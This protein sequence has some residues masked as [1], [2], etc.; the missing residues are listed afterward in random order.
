VREQGVKKT[1]AFGIVTSDPQ[2]RM[3]FQAACE[4]LG[5]RLG[6]VVYPQIARS[7]AEL[8]EIFARGSVELAWTP[9]LIAAELVERKLA[10]VAVVSKR[11][12]AAQYRSVIFVRRDSGR[13]T[14]GDLAGSHVAWVD[15][16]SASGYIVPRAYLR[17][18]GH[19]PDELFAYQTIAAS[20]GAV[21]RMVLSR[22]ADAGATFALFSSGLRT[23]IEAGWTEIDPKSAD[24]IHV[25]VNAGI[26]PADCISVA[27]KLAPDARKRLEDAL[28]GLTPEQRADFRKSVGAEGY[29]R[30]PLGHAQSLKR[31]RLE[32]MRSGMAKRSG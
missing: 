29:E 11:D 32:A 13:L 16:T 2:K 23:T 28:I 15:P 7:Y 8:E 12:N 21:A 6:G 17:D 18:N 14:M 22:E 3:R 20:H 9:P 30:P 31:L 4:H 10:I 5:R 25:V 19:P 24:E 27:S 1:F 26:V